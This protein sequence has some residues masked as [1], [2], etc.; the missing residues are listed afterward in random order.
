[1]K[2]TKVL[3]EVVS[4]KPVRELWD[5]WTKPEHITQWC[6]ALDTW[7][8]PAAE[9]DLRVNGRFK[10]RME[11]KDGSMGFDFEGVYTAVSDLKRIDYKLADGREVSVRF[12][13]IPGGVKISELFDIETINSPEIQ[14]NGWQAILDNFKKYADKTLK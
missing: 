13:E 8:A 14:R 9:N 11:A 1:M 3:V 5:L 4:S 10:T 6:Y 2:T 7:Y 12:D